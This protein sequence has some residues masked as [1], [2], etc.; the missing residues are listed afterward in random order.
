[1][2][3]A[4]PA[5]P[6]PLLA[7]LAACAALKVAVDGGAPR[8]LL[9][10]AVVGTVAY[11]AFLAA[12]RPRD[13]WLDGPRAALLALALVMLPS[14][15]GE[16]GGD[17]L[18]A[19]A[20]VRSVVLDRDL[21]L[22]DEYLG[23][24]K[25]AVIDATGR[26]TSHLP[27]GLA[28]FWAPAFVLAHVGSL[29]ARAAGAAV[30]TDGFGVPYRSAAATATFIYGVAALFLLEAV[31]RRRHGRGV[32]LLAVLAV[33]LATPMRFYTVANP[34]MA[35][36]V[37][38][39]AA[40]SVVATWLRA[41]DAEGA[42]WWV[43]AGLAGGLM[44]LVRLQDGVLLA[45]P[46]LDLLL[47]RPPRW[48]LLL[49]YAAA[50]AGVLGLQLLFWLR[51][52]GT[53][54]AGTVRE[55]NLVGGTGL[56][57]ADLLFSARHGLFTWT[58]LY[59]L[60]VLGWILWLRHQP[61]PAALVLGG[62]AASVV[63]NAAMQDW[64]GSEAFG[65]R[66]L[67]GLTPLFALGLGEAFAALA[68]RPLLVLTAALVP[69]VAWNVGFEGVYN[70]QV[71]A[72]R[73][74]AIP[75]EAATAAQL[76][77]VSR[78]VVAWHG[79]IPPRLWARLWDNVRGVWLDEGSRSLGDRID[80]GAEP[81]ELPFLATRGWYDPE[82]EDGVTLRRSRGRG[83]WLRVPIRTAGP[84]R[85]VV[86][87]RPEVPDLPLRVTFEVNRHPVG[88]VDVRPGWSE[89]EFAVPDGLVRPG[90]NDL[91]LIYST[92]PREGRPGYAGRNAAVAVDWVALRA[93]AVSA[94]GP[95]GARP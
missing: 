70:S 11:A 14:V 45:L 4:A 53:G 78:K 51:M 61:R 60:C 18:Q 13:G 66:R 73:D 55:V 34:S 37:S 86:R 26:A 77:A 54:F 83:S 95:P 72:R 67:L 9:V 22:A 12:G 71:V 89:Y 65:Q 33:W 47:R 31:L 1:V 7:A 15:Y 24:G 36:G 84:R 19:F 80:L 27:V 29:L 28:L 94:S 35:H 44:T 91:G 10:T 40:T 16:V 6:V 38:V 2:N 82:T 92:T 75:L 17:G 41:R 52:Y 56:H 49:R 74:E 32:A 81:P 3:P 23:L 69:L 79:H 25:G 88:V 39:F 5:P 30:G 46:V 42:R 57:V 93:D 64:W 63:V 68:A 50:A 62:F 85:A 90:L 87:L 8:S 76:D 48:P 21:D 59:L 58:P 43:Y 20:V